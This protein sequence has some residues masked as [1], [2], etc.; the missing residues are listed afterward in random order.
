RVRVQPTAG[1]DGES[2]RLLYGLHGEITGRLDHDSALATDPGDD[3]GP[4][5]VIVASTGLPLLPATTRSAP[6]RLPA[7]AFR[8][9]LVASGVVE[10]IGFHRPPQLAIHLIGQGGIA[11]PPAPAITRADM[12]TYFPRD[13]PR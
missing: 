3:R 2:R 1:L 4:V 10:V 8:L 6:Q 9:P 12:D 7:T 11:Q 13:A 5:F